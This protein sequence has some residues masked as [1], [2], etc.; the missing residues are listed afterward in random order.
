MFV[1][2][3][4]RRKTLRA[5]AGW[6]KLAHEYMR[7]LRRRPRFAGGTEMFIFRLIAIVF[8]ARHL[9]CAAAAAQEKKTF[10][11]EIV[12]LQDASGKAFLPHG[13]PF[14]VRLSNLSDNPI[15]VWQ[16]LCELGH[17]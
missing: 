12:A 1:L 17:H 4:R 5:E 6:D 10:S 16:D 9:Y 13:E 15:V 7:H 14:E 3:R 2:L 8:C 11:I